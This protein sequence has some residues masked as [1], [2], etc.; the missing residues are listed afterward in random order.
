MLGP[1]AAHPQKR[2]LGFSAWG[3]QI[4]VL[5]SPVTLVTGSIQPHNGIHAAFQS[6]TVSVPQTRS[7]EYIRPMI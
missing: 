5:D 6:A 1:I 2:S 4:G 7:I 3:V